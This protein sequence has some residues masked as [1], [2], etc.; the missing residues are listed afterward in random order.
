MGSRPTPKEKFSDSGSA[1]AAACDRVADEPQRD[2]DG[3]GER[4]L[5]ALFSDTFYKGKVFCPPPARWHDEMDSRC[6]E[7]GLLVSAQSAGICN[8]A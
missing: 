5:K 1:A 8:A 7:K 2:R 3:G 6:E 4:G